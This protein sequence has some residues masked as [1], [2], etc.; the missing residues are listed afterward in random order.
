MNSGPDL[1]LLGF[2]VGTTI[3]AAAV[4]TG[5]I[6]PFGSGGPLR[7]LPVA[8][9]EPSITGSVPIQAPAPAKQ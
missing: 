1:N 4:V 8:N 7:T 9:I 5:G 3:I 2:A 6:M